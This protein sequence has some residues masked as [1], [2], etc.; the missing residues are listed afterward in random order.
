MT[1]LRVLREMM[2]QPTN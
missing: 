1:A 2:Q